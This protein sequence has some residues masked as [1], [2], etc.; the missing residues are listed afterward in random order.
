MLQ[1]K[2]TKHRRVFRIPHDKTK[3]FKG[4]RVSFGEYGLQAQTSA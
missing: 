1:P 2:K 3:A 4:N